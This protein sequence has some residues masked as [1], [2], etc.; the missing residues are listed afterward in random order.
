M[1]L[2]IICLIWYFLR[3]NKIASSLVIVLAV[4][5]G[6]NM[7]SRFTFINSTEYILI[8]DLYF[9]L[10]STL[11]F[12]LIVF[13]YL[14]K[15][16]VGKIAVYKSVKKSK[17]IV[18]LWVLVII[19]NWLKLVTSYGGILP[20][21]FDSYNVFSDYE[22]DLVQYTFFLQLG[23][24][25]FPIVL[26]DENMKN[27]RLR[28]LVLLLLLVPP[29]ISVL[30]HFRRSV[31]IM[32]GLYW[33]FYIIR[34][35]GYIIQV[36]KLI[37]LGIIALFAVMVF[38][39]LRSVAYSGSLDIASLI[40]VNNM[41]SSKTMGDYGN[42]V[43][44]AMASLNGVNYSISILGTVFKDLVPSKFIGRELKDS[45]LSALGDPRKVVFEEFG[46]NLPGNE[47]MGG[48]ALLIHD[49]GIFYILSGLLL[50]MAL[51]FIDD[52]R[53]KSP[54]LHAIFIPVFINGLI[55]SPHVVIIVLLKYLFLLFTISTKYV[56]I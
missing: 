9:S 12:V 39:K 51:R 52:R 38:P 32:Y 13:G 49:F 29:L 42:G 15:Y 26:F 55:F 50:G 41:A 11:F 54:A 34:D 2:Q 18:L 27:W 5:L 43:Y 33:L 56:K 25:L 17:L 53:W 35:K 28:R 21:L 19:Y 16:R 48:V 14:S 24:L 47:Y 37:L 7:F 45:I 30:F 1:I 36:K 3:S 46:L 6:F 23:H 10:L 22:G 4:T 20:F 40:G 44:V 31:L 8:F